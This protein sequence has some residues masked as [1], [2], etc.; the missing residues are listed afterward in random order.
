MNSEKRE[1]T[2]DQRTGE[3]AQEPLGDLLHEISYN[4]GL[5]FELVGMLLGV[6]SGAIR[7]WRREDRI[8]LDKKYEL[9]ALIAFCQEMGA[10]EP[11][12]GATSLW[13]ESP[14][15]AD[16]GITPADLSLEGLHKDLLGIASGKAEANQVLDKK[17]PDWRNRFPLDQNHIVIEASDGRR[18]IVP[19]D[20]DRESDDLGP[21][22]RAKAYAEIA[23]DEERSRVICDSV[24]NTAK[25]GLI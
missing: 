8:P 4:Q 12:I 17:I 15:T 18:S 9:A 10:I 5:S 20:Q 25:H 13:L 22:E 6:A 1:Q 24:L 2:L 7:K 3:I 16:S 21:A 19:G 14:L 11:S 23:R